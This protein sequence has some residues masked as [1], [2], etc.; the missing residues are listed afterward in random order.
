MPDLI[1]LAMA[2]D[3]M[4]PWEVGLQIWWLILAR[5]YFLLF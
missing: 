1:R 5:H 4:H 2:L 3:G